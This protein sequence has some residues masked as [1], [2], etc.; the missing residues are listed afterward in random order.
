MTRKITERE[1]GR[2]RAQRSGA[3]NRNRCARCGALGMARVGDLT[4]TQRH[5]GL[6]GGGARGRPRNDTDDHGK[7]D[8]VVLVLSVAVLVIVIDARDVGP[9]G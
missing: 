5:G 9:W 8:G 4:E 2:A 7:G 3:R 6:L 1:S